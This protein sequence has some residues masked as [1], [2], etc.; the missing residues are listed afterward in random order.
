MRTRS[1]AKPARTSRS[2]L[3]RLLLAL[4]ICLGLTTP[5]ATHTASA[6]ETTLSNP[7]FESGDLKGWTTTGTAFTGAV[8]DK[9]GW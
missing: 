8:T 9:P 7:G 5:L 2:T 4:T 3:L 1:P 6:A